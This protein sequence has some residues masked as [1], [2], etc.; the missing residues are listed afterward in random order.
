MNDKYQHLYTISWTQPYEHF[1]GLNTDEIANRI[2]ES[3]ID[4]GELADAQKALE[5]IMKL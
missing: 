3:L 1:N 4:H 2:I 5:R